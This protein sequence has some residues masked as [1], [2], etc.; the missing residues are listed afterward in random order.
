MWVP[1]EELAE[2]AE[3]VENGVPLTPGLEHALFHGSSM[4]GARPKAVVVDG[5]RQMVAKF[6]SVVD[7]F[8]VVKAEYVAMELARRAGLEVAGVGLDR[9]LGP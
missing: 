6:T 2:V 9:V 4:G 5:M 7:S 8:P 3:R 1:L